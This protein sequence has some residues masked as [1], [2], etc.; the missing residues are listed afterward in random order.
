MSKFI[1]RGGQIVN[2]DTNENV[3]SISGKLVAVRVIKP[4]D[5]P[6]RLQIDLSDGEVTSTLT[7]RKSGD[8]SMKILRCLY[9]IVDVMGDKVITVSTEARE[10]RSSLINL[11]AD[12]ERLAPMG[13]PGEFENV[14]KVLIDK[15]LASLTR[16]LGYKQPVL[17]YSNADK[18][19]P[20]TGDQSADAEQI[21]DYIRDLRRAG[22]VGEITVKKTVF[23]N[24]KSALAYWKA[25]RD[26]ESFSNMRIFSDAEAIE[27]ISQAYTA[28]LESPA[29][30][31]DAPEGSAP[32]AA[33]EEEA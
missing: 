24:E 28:P 3:E 9:G 6:E 25:L 2:K 26:V 29:S 7:V 13:V 30:E 4:E 20:S 11:D 16:A 23:T 17:V 32:A 8:V 18:V 33:D 21:A 12:G 19:Y 14:R 1:I 22:R 27:T 15:I 31:G 10:G 5:A